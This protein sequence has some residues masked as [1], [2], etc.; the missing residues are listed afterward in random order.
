MKRWYLFL[1]LF[2]IITICS[3]V[4]FGLKITQNQLLISVDNDYKNSACFDFIIK[5]EDGVSNSD[6]N[7]ILDND[8]VDCAEKLY[9]FEYKILY[10]GNSYTV[11]I[12]S[13]NQELTSFRIFEGRN[14]KTDSECMVDRMFSELTGCGIGDTIS[15]DMNYVFDNMLLTK[16]QLTIVGICDSVLYLDYDR[17]L[18]SNKSEF[19]TCFLVVGKECFQEN[20][21]FLMLRLKNTLI[22]PFSPEYESALAEFE[23]NIIALFDSMQQSNYLIATAEISKQTE[24]TENDL[25]DQYTNKSELLTEQKSELNRLY[26]EWEKAKSEAEE[27]RIKI[28]E[29]RE[30]LYAMDYTEADADLVLLTEQKQL[31]TLEETIKECRQIYNDS[32]AFYKTAIPEAE[33]AISE[34]ERQLEALKDNYSDIECGYFSYIKR[35]DLTSYQ[36]I[37]NQY[38]S[39]QKK[40]EQVYDII[41]WILY[42]TSGIFILLAFA[43]F[44]NEIK[45]CA[46]YENFTHW[47]ISKCIL[48][49]AVVI[50]GMILGGVASASVIQKIIL[51]FLYPGF[52]YLSSVSNL[53][54]LGSYVQD[55]IKTAALSLVPGMVVFIILGFILYSMYKK[56]FSTIDYTDNNSRSTDNA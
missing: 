34:K 28:Q 56:K 51:D 5:A 26:S 1:P 41:S 15:R 11:C 13:D 30:R 40:S 44:I 43:G 53:C 35:T 52:Y 18:T 31:E 7:L 47:I 49:I 22:S 14:P 38:Q 12:Y 25:K 23:N 17:S 9:A 50:I 27:A 16:D 36:K 39:S 32:V 33:A 46:V 45:R 2:A 54:L 42:V 24:L 48:M 8:Q 55:M 29:H 19:T 21:G 37:I 3:A 10:S 20:A 6:I 4:L